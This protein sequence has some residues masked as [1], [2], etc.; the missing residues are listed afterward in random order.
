M[1]PTWLQTHLE[2]IG[3]HNPD[4]ISRRARTTLCRNCGQVVLRGL[5]DDRAALPATCDPHPLEPCGEASA[6]LTG[7][8]TYQLTWR[9]DHYEINR[10]DALRITGRPAGTDA[11]VVADHK[12][13]DPLPPLDAS[14]P[15]PA[16]NRE[17]E[18][19]DDEPPF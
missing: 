6:L 10:R 16:P 17:E 5:D 8:A 19:L 2:T 9:G 13:H 1:I 11:H 15:V 12:C 14:P 3:R 18:R 4:G 7:R